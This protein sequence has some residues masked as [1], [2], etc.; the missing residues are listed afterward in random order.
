[1]IGHNTQTMS[2][3]PAKQTA[4]CLIFNKAG[5]ILILKVAGKEDTW[6]FPGG[7]R[8]CT[9]NKIGSSL[10]R[11]VFE[12][13]KLG[14]RKTHPLISKKIE[15]KKRHL[16]AAFCK[17]STP[18]ITIDPKESDGYIWVTPKELEKYKLKPKATNLVKALQSKG[19][20]S[21][22]PTAMRKGINQLRLMT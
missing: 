19:I 13:T 4:K 5:Q 20:T 1:M 11:E 16:F 15:G 3:K 18:T 12:E 6:D 17:G 9:K 21:Q 7:N 8:E 2:K 14:L 10:L 22:L